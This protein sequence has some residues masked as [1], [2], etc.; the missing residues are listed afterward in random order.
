MQP[1]RGI[2][3]TRQLEHAYSARWMH[4]KEMPHYIVV[5]LCPS[6][7]LLHVTACDNAVVCATV[8]NAP[9]TIMSPCVNLSS[10]ANLIPFLPPTP[11]SAVVSEMLQL[12]IDMVKTR[13]GMMQQDY[14]K[15]FLTIVT[16]L[17]EKSPVC[18]GW[19]LGQGQGK[20]F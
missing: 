14:R 18:W 13:V 19:G 6:H 5:P 17:I 9:V 20:D 8:T 4:S 11:P 3:V 2:P 15:T 7:L 16:A 12:C 10:T 1:V